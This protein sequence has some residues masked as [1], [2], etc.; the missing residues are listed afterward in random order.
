MCCLK[1][2]ISTDTKPLA[3]S[4][5]SAIVRKYDTNKCTQVKIMYK[6][7]GIYISEATVGGW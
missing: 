6:N 5:P 3:T 7:T 1:L 2:Y 4:I